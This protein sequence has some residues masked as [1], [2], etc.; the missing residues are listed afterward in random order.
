MGE[1][2]IDEISDT[3]DQRSLNQADICDDTQ[4]CM[5]CRGNTEG[6]MC[7]RYDNGTVL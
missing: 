5:D 3:K 4:A 1:L 7:Q 6:A 2:K